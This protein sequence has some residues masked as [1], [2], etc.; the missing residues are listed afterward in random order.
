MTKQLHFSTTSEAYSETQC[1]D[2]I[3]TGDI[4]IVESEKAVGLADTWPVAI[5]VE[6]GEFHTIGAG[7]DIN[8]ESFDFSIDSIILANLVASKYGWPIADASRSLYI[9]I[10]KMFFD[11]HQSRDLD[12][13]IVYRETGKHYYIKRDDPALLELI[14]DANYYADTFDGWT[15]DAHS[16][17]RGARALCAALKR[18]G[19]KV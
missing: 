17:V 10:P 11:D 2:D 7:Y 12:T 18:Q 3:K 16:Y 9:R 5:T 8:D 15:L 13:P 14:D 6:N 4:L 1:R 19:V